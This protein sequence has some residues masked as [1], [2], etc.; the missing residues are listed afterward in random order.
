MP[1][2][3]E[4]PVTQSNNSYF[5]L[6]HYSLNFTTHQIMVC[7]YYPFLFGK[8]EHLDMMALLNLEHYY[9]IADKILDKHD[10]F[11]R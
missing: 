5:T 6:F 10:K 3:T 1:A 8:C 7:G 9:V 11:D 2:L 4:S